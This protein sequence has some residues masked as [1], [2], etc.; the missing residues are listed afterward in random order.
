MSHLSSEY[1]VGTRVAYRELALV[2]PVETMNTNPGYGFAVE[3]GEGNFETEVLR[4]KVPVMVAFGAPWS[5]PCR[6]L[7][8]VLQELLATGL[9]GIKVVKVNADEYPGLG[10]WYEVQSI[11]TLLYFIDGTLRFRTV[12]TVSKEAIL[13]QLQLLV[14]RETRVPSQGTEFNRPATVPAGP[15]AGLSIL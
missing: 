13:T 3:A 12:G 11:P 14:R 2:N 15:D 10:L 7:E 4:S 5:A 8:S 6:S 1:P 9:E